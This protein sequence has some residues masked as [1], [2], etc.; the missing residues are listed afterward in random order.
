MFYRIAYGLVTVLFKLLYRMKMTG[1]E[2]R[3]PLG[4]GAL[5]CGNHTGYSDPV[6]A[7]LAVGSG[8]QTRFMAKESLFRNKPFAWLI[9]KLGAFPVSRGKTDMG[10]VK[11][12][13][14]SLKDGKRLIMFPEGTRVR[15]GVTDAEA[16][17]GAG[18]LA[19]RSGCP[20]LPV[21]LTPYK[22]IFRTKV[23]VVIGTPF[24]PEQPEGMSGKEAYQAVSDEIMARVRALAPA[25]DREKA[26]RRA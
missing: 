19:L 14:K 4:Q 26:G 18:M 21:Y 8:G 7:A 23:Q 12:A 1:K 3:P 22:K 11:T 17:A 25:A 10:A 16:K 2:N 5:V 6:F 15:E 9:T 24:M 13:L 20:V